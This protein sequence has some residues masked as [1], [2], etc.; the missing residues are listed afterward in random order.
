[1]R[2]KEVILESDDYGLGLE[3]SIED[4]ADSRGDNYLLDVLYT[5]RNE[6][7]ESD[8]I[9]PRVS[10][11]TIIDRVREIP[12]NEAFNYTLLVNAMNDNTA[13]KNLVKG[14]PQ[15]DPKTGDKYVYMKPAD[16]EIG[17]E[18][19]STGEA[20]S[21]DAEANQK[22]VQSMADRALAKRN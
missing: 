16:S 3:S 22:T 15:D 6:A 19:T 10:V 9:T 13:V 2:I 21:M 5:L 8:A 12:G 11:K 18:D 17:P 14:K 1:M 4:E 20:G 7:A